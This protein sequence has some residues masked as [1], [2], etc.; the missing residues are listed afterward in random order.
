MSQTLTRRLY[1]LFGRLP[2][3][4]RRLAVRLGTPSYTVGAVCV[5]EHDG[6][7]LLL[8]QAH[9]ED[10]SL[11]GGLLDRGESPR[12]AVT[13]ELREELGLQVRV[14]E[15]VTVSL[16]PELRRADVVYRIRLDRR[17]SPQVAGEALRAQWLRP[18]QLG[19]DSELTRDL[20]L[21]VAAAD[22]AGARD[23]RVVA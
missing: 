18:E 7:V 1:A 2:A 15:P 16:D 5:L 13:R 19:A 3:P 23:G 12:A 21:R 22:E 11:P 4:V 9:R 20:L 14:G 17:I 6:E 8:R 10:W